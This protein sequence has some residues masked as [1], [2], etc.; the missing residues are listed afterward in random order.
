MEKLLPIDGDAMVTAAVLTKHLFGNDFVG[1]VTELRENFP[2]EADFT[3]ELGNMVMMKKL[4]DLDSA[5][6]T[7]P[8]P[9]E[10]MPRGH[11]KRWRGCPLMRPRHLTD[12]LA[13]YNQVF[14]PEDCSQPPSLTASHTRRLT[15]LM[16]MSGN[17][18]S[19]PLNPCW[20]P[21]GGMF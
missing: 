17:V 16:R 6:I 9:I 10:G 2:K 4:I 1:P 13:L 18:P 8:E 20:R 15:R 7:M 5:H 14:A 21:L 11:V 12:M 3:C 19:G